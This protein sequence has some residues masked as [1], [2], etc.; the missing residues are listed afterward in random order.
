[1]RCWRDW[2]PTA[3]CTCPSAWPQLGVLARRGDYVDAAAQIMLPFVGADVAPE[4]FRRIC[5]DAYATFRHRAVCPLVQLGRTSGCWSCSTARRWPSRT[6]PFSSSAGSSITSSVSAAPRITILGAT[7]GDT[8]SA[9]IDGVKGC[10]HIDIVMLYPEGRCQRGAAAP[11]DHD[12]R[13][14][15]P[16]LAIEGTF[17]DCQDLVKAI[18]GDEALP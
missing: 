1:M 18:F 12:R 3:A 5:V 17:D 10:T 4:Q 14:E 15:R 13:T 9:A 8:G 6:L 16:C 2:P 7:S 11:D